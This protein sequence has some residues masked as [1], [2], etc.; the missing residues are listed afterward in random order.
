[1]KLDP[2]NKQGMWLCNALMIRK[3]IT[4]DEKKA[5]SSIQRQII[6]SPLEFKPSQI[7]IACLLNLWW[8]GQKRPSGRIKVEIIETEVLGEHRAVRG[9]GLICGRCGHQVEVFGTGIASAKRG[10][11]M[12]RDECPFSEKNFYDVSEW[13][14]S[15]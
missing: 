14:K 4:D 8:R 3:D 13:A 11:V 9:L 6:A 12:L 5:V 7:Q 15:M 2:D 1:M 10:A